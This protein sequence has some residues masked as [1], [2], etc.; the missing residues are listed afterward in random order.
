MNRRPQRR[1]GYN[2]L[3]KKRKKEEK[4]RNNS[5]IENNHKMLR[6]LPDF[7]L[8]FY[9]KQTRTDTIFGENGTMAHFIYPDS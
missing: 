2:H 8:A 9:F 4:K 6:I 5:F 1:V 3:K 7:Q